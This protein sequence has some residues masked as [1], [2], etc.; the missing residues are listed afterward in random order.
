MK[1]SMDDLAVDERPSAYTGADRKVDKIG[2]AT[3]GAPAR[4]AGRSGV[5]IG[6][7]SD[8]DIEGAVKG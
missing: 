5:D 8:R 6:V 1:K 3:A 4:L 2:E 7:E